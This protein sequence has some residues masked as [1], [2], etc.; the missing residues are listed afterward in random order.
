MTILPNKK[1]KTIYNKKN[2]KESK[3]GTATGVENS[4]KQF[5]LIGLP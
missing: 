5:I 4:T 1:P 3:T 2:K